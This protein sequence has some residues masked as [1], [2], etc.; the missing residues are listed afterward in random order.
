[1]TEP[2]LFDAPEPTGPPVVDRY[3]GLGKD[4]RRTAKQA[5]ALSVGIH[6]GTRL[7]LHPAAA[8]ATDKDRPGF[9]C[10]TCGNKTRKQSGGWSGWK[11]KLTAAGYQDGPD[12]RQWWPACDR[13]I[14]TDESFRPGDVVRLFTGGAYYLVAGFAGPQMNLDPFPDHLNGSTRRAWRV[15]PADYTLVRPVEDTPPPKGTP[16]P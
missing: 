3:A 5:D 8:P 10:G 1:M 9:R 11:C 13:F 4:A 15:D 12:L 16:A 2:G 7:P 6:P 14:P